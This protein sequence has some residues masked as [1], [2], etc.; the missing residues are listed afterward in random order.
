ME[1]DIKT[2]QKIRVPKDEKKQDKKSSRQKESHAVGQDKQW[3]FTTKKN[4]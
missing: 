1:K 3:S 4:T 2:R